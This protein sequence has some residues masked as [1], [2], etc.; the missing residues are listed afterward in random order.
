[1]KKNIKKQKR[2][3]YLKQVYYNPS[4][5]AS[6]SGIQKLAH[7]IKKRGKYKFSQGE[8]TKWLK[9]QEGHTTN[10]LAN[11]HTKRRKVVVPYID[12]MWDMDCASMRDY[13]KENKGYTHFLLAIDIMS[14]YVWAQPIK[15]PSGEEVKKALK[16]EIFAGKR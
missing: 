4:K 6:F 2:E 8:I 5:A 1:M 12:Y 3:N 10:I 11:Y 7:Y 16:N 9:T 13:S 14:R 15:T